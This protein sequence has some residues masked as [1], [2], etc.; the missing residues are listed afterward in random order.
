MTHPKAKAAQETRDLRNRKRE[1]IKY[2]KARLGVRFLHAGPYTLCY[3]PDVRR[4][5]RVSTALKH[6]NDRF[7][8]LEAEHVALS[9]FVQGESVLLR[10]PSG[11]KITP[12][13]YLSSVFQMFHYS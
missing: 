3:K 9:R 10:A 7:D 6:P 4:V 2:G 12:K 13:Q 1:A 5:L 8:K 11:S